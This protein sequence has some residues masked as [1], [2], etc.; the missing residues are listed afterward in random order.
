MVIIKN[1]QSGYTGSIGGIV[2]QV[3]L[4]DNKFYPRFH[5][6]YL[7]KVYLLEWACF[8]IGWIK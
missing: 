7:K 5:K 8:A 1:K 6:N 3:S 4:T 2:F